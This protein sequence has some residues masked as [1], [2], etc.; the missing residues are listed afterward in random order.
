MRILSGT[1]EAG[2]LVT[3]NNSDR[4]IWALV[5]PFDH[6]ISYRFGSHCAVDG[7]GGRTAVERLFRNPIGRRIVELGENA[8]LPRLFTRVHLPLLTPSPRFRVRG[9]LNFGRQMVGSYIGKVGNNGP[10]RYQPIVQ[11]AIIKS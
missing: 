10:N 2:L 4:A 5:P 9:Q 11:F 6:R 7:S 1:G 8:N 3:T